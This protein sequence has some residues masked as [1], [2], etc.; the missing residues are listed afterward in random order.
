MYMY[1]EGRGGGGICISVPPPLYLLEVGCEHVAFC[2]LKTRQ[3]GQK[4]VV[5]S[6]N[7]YLS[8]L[9]NLFKQQEDEYFCGAE[10]F[11]D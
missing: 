1:W 4:I 5:N 3:Q 6:E 7:P 8:A 2:G 10:C 9:V 11:I